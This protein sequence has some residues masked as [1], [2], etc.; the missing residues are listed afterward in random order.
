[1]LMESLS[2]KPLL[3]YAVLT[4]TGPH[5]EGGM[6]CSRYQRESRSRGEISGRVA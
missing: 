6:Q 4:F 2:A 3:P 1:M 5:P